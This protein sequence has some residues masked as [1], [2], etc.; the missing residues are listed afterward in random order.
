MKATT[1]ATDKE[2][3][4][5]YRIAAA[6]A[7]VP[8]SVVSNGSGGNNPP[9]TKPSF[10]LSTIGSR[11]LMRISLLVVMPVLLVQARPSAS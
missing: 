4:D 11:E 6:Q 10:Y 3:A 5:D 7:P 2:D 1:W 9:P 8:L